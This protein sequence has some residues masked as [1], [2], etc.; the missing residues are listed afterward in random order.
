MCDIH[1]R[2]DKLEW[3]GIKH[4]WILNDCSNW[5]GHLI[6]CLIVN[7]WCTVLTKAYLMITLLAKSKLV[8]QSL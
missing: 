8:T 7:A 3:F 6:I 5:K 2:S 1:D 4:F